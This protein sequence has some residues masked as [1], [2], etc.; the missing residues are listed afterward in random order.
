MDKKTIIKIQFLFYLSIILIVGAPYFP[1][2]FWNVIY[3]YDVNFHEI[4]FTQ[5]IPSIRI[6]GI[7]LSAWGIALLLKSRKEK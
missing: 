4:R 6:C 7:L 1:S 5:V 3:N 2:I